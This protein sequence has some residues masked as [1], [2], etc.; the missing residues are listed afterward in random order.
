MAD[1]V[2]F[3]RDLRLGDHGALAAADGQSVVPL[4]VM[5]PVLLASAGGVRRERL[6]ASLRSLDRS[7]RES[8]GA[9]LLVRSYSLYLKM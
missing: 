1:I 5:D 6:F 2:W 9:G 7:I 4:F 8:G 3:R